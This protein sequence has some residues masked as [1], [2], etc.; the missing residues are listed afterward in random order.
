MLS[1][2]RR[3]FILVNYTP[4]HIAA[5][6]NFMEIAQ[7]LVNHN[8]NVN[9]KMNAQLPIK[10]KVGGKTPLHIVAEN[11]SIDVGKILISSKANFN[12]ND[13]F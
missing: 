3:K 8:A 1:N 11:N 6:F 4:L 2:K 10:D 9:A 12:L 13:I 5:E 7:L